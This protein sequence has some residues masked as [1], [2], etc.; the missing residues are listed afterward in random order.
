M[1]T[2]VEDRIK[3]WLTPGLI[4]C[5]GMV[6]WSLITEIRS[7]VKTLLEANAQVQI[8]IQ[9]LEKRMDGVED[10][11]YSQRMFAI[12]PKETSLPKKD[13]KHN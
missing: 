13:E 6:S 12:L 10:I 3:S 8:K 4:T 7:D 2:S 11:I 5:F 1:A 9:N